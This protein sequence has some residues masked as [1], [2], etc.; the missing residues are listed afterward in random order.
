[1]FNKNICFLITNIE[2][3]QYI[4]LSR[5]KLFPAFHTCIQYIIIPSQ[6]HKQFII[7]YTK[8]IME[9]RNYIRIY[10]SNLLNFFDMRYYSVNGN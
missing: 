3:S 9:L 2:F 7:K 10:K 1:M 5:K 6:K 8:N 4:N